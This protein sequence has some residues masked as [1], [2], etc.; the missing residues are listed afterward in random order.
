MSTYV[1][2]DLQAG[3]DAARATPPRRARSRY[4]IHADGGV[5]PVINQ[6]KTGFSVDMSV[7]PQLRGHV[8][9]YN[10]ETHVAR[11]LILASEE[12]AGIMRYDFKRTTP[13]TDS[14][15]ADFV[16]DPDAPVAL[17]TG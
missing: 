1:S 2:Q 6:W 5:Y 4:R 3:L 11:C 8:D 7:V 15:P 9:L 13:A 14:A 12:D 16:R 10:G 17:I